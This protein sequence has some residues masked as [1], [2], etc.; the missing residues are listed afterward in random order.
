MAD[1]GIKLWIER[2]SSS[3]PSARAFG[4]RFN[5]EKER[6]HVRRGPLHFNNKI[7]SI[8]THGDHNF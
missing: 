6:E 8:I 5:G 4:L 7:L 1:A 3:P 2:T